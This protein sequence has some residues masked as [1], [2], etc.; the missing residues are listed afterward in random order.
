MLTNIGMHG[1]KDSESP[2][3]DIEMHK[4]CDNCH[5]SVPKGTPLKFTV[6]GYFCPFC[7]GVW[8]ATV[9]GK[10]GTI[11]VTDEDGTTFET[12]VS[13]NG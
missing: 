11:S 6:F 13:P 2:E 1:N 8:E 9:M 3:E 10:G 12:T 7:H 4:R 5:E